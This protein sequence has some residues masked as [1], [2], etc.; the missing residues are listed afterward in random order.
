ML[1][2]FRYFQI[3]QYHRQYLFLKLCLFFEQLEAKLFASHTKQ[4]LNPFLKEGLITFVFLN[5]QKLD[6]IYLL[7]IINL[8]VHLFLA[9]FSLLYFL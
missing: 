1:E 2:Y 7:A 9:I 4:S 6:A 3:S 8:F 5:H